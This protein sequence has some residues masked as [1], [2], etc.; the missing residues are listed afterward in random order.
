M[1]IPDAFAKIN[2]A[3][4]H[5][6]IETYKFTMLITNVESAP[7]VSHLPFL[8]DQENGPNGTLQDGA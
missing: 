4:P 6:L 8:L 2:T 1:Y 5:G 7:F 3:R